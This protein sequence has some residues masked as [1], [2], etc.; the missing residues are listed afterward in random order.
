[1]RQAL[2][3]LHRWQCL[4]NGISILMYHAVGTDGEP[5]SRFVIPVKRFA[6]QMKLLKNLGYHVLD[7]E[8]YLRLRLE[9]R[10]LPTRSI[11]ITFDDG[12]VDNWLLAIPVLRRY[13]FPSTI[14]LVSHRIGTVQN[15]DQIGALSGRQLLSWDNL[16]AMQHENIRFGAHSCTHAHLTDIPVDQAR[17]E[18]EGSKSD[19]EQKLEAAI[20]VFCYPYGD[21]NTVTQKLVEQAGFWGS[22]SSDSGL[23]SP[24]SPLHALRRVEIYGTDSL[25][26]FLCAI[27]L[28]E[29]ISSLQKRLALPVLEW[30]RVWDRS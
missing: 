15:W 3:D 22:C 13:A 19:L 12:Y 14:F 9:H 29:R 27:Y 6:L 11:I 18:I 5:A 28:G 8:E 7:L 21:C 23:N 24:V 26:S 25:L 1:M 16:R 2:P 17:A 4:S 20:H 30:L 10:L